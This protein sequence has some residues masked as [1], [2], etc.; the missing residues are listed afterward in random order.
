MRDV[1]VM[2]RM[3]E[4]RDKLLAYGPTTRDSILPDAPQ[5]KQL[6]IWGSKKNFECINTTPMALAELRAALAP[7]NHK[8]HSITYTCNQI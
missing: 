8:T 1:R 3:N 4:D 2:E 5:Y 6:Y 7:G